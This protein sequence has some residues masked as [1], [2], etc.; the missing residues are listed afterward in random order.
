MLESKKEAVFR[1]E[2]NIETQKET[3]SFL[4]HVKVHELCL[5]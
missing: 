5:F 1:V 3:A 2:N 4:K